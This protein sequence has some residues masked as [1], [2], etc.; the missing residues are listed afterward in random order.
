MSTAKPLLIYDG[1]CG[2]CRAWIARLRRATGERVEYAPF[3]EAAARFPEIPRQR[4]ADSVQLL[5]PD[6]RWSQGAEAVFRSLAYAPGRGWL[7]WFYRRAPGFAPASEACYRFVARHR[8]GLSRLTA[9]GWGPELTPP[10]ERLTSWIA[11]FGFGKRTGIDFPGESAGLVIPLE[12]WSGSTIGNVPI[13]QG[14]AVTPV[15]MAAGY[16]AI[17]RARSAT[18]SCRRCAGST[19][20]TAS[21]WGCARP[22]PCSRSCSSPASLR[23]RY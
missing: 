11:R 9:W 7:L 16:A 10:G 5:E 3:Q 23:S 8:T 14:I 22:A 18:G 17:R 19:R 6:G 13:G 15:Q 21:S 20:A 12:K 1:E 2:F 4:F